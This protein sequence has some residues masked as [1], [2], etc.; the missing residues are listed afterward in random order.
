MS[1]EKVLERKLEKYLKREAIKMGGLALK[2]ES[3]SMA[4][5]PDDILF[6]RG[7]ITFIELKT[8]DGVLSPRQKAC[9]RIFN[10]HGVY[11]YT[12]HGKVGIDMFLADIK[13]QIDTLCE[14][15]NAPQP[16]PS[17]IITV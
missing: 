6:Y 10:N 5:V 13:F 14:E 7:A 12:L 9:H 17:K 8:D 3:P 15:K 16:E 2:F 11:V 4:G 1:Q